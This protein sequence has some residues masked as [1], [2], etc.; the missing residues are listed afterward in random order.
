MRL[1]EL[2]EQLG[3]QDFFTGVM[4]D[5]LEFEVVILNTDAAKYE[6]IHSVEWQHNEQRVV[7]QP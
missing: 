2:L 4:N 3:V 6:A 1:Q 7:I 5:E